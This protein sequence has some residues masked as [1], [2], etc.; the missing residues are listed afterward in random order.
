MCWNALQVGILM[1]TGFVFLRRQ[2]GEILYVSR[3]YGSHRDLEPFQYVMPYSMDPQRPNDFTISHML[4][5]FTALS[6]Q[7][8]A[9]LETRLQEKILVEKARRANRNQPVRSSEFAAPTPSNYSLPQQQNSSGPFSNT[10]YAL[11]SSDVFL[12]FTPW[13]PETHL[14]GRAWSGLRLPDKL[15]VIIKCWDSYKN[16]AK[17]QETEVEV[18]LR[19]HELWGICIPKFIAVG[20]VGYCYA[21][22]AERLKVSSHEIAHLGY[23]SFEK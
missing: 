15:P 19:L 8:P 5:W 14:G 6:E 23:H 10:Q 22:V 13:K 3:M 12:N 21:I 17:Q 4:Y 18:Y 7:L 16:S 2:D 11:L 20:I 9:L 1:T